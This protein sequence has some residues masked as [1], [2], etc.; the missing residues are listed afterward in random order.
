MKRFAASLTTSAH[1]SVLMVGR[2]Y[3]LMA[4]SV[5]GVIFGLWRYRSRAATTTGMFVLT[6]GLSIFALVS[7]G[8]WY[9]LRYTCSSLPPF[10]LLGAL[11]AYGLAELSARLTAGRLS[12][13]AQRL[14]AALVTVALLLVFVSPNITAARADPHRKLDWRGVATFME[15]IA[16]DGE[17]IVIANKWPETCLGYYLQGSDRDLEFID[18]EESVARGQRM[19]DRYPRGWLMTAGFR[20]TGEVRAWMHGFQPVL[21]KREEEM[22]LFFFPDFVTLMETRFAAGKGGF[23]EEQFAAMNQRYD[24]GGAELTLQGGGWSYQETNKAG[25]SYQWA[26]GEQAELGLPI[27]PVRDS[28]IRFRALPFTY[29]EA[30]EQSVELWLNEISLGRFDLPRGWS[31]HQVSVPAETWSPG[32]NVLFLRFA[33]ST[34]PAQVAPGSSDRRNLSAAFDFLEVVDAGT[35]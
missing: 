18:L 1:R 11:G 13:R 35:G 27:G 30:P 34:I 26:L 29:P 32:A 16:I 23:F 12:E 10:L 24:F 31:E 3:I 22:A 9:A 2:S 6:A 25:I 21:K 20:M 8:R 33:R 15:E 19:V 7:T 4:F 5:I 28:V 17:P 14:T